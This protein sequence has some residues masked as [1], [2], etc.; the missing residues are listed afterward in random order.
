MVSDVNSQSMV[1]DTFESTILAIASSCLLVRD[2]KPAFHCSQ[3]FE[4]HI[5]LLIIS[6]GVITLP[7]SDDSLVRGIG[8]VMPWKRGGIVRGRA[9]GFVGERDRGGNGWSGQR[10]W[11]SVALWW[12]RGG[13]G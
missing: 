13:F 10:W 8:V 9:G 3:K 2:R 5:I 11:E 6:K 7:D 4:M 12:E 1:S